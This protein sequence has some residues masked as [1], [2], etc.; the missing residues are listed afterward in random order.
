ML[1]VV[2]PISHLEKKMFYNTDTI[3]KVIYNLFHLLLMLYKN[4]LVRL[5]KATVSR[6]V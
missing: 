1:S 5:A 4:T 3:L 6:L 2:A